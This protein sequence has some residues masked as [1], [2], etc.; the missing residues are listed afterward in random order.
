EPAA[1]P[2][3]GPHLRLR[4]GVIREIPHAARPVGPPGLFGP[5]TPAEAAGPL[6]GGLA[7]V[8]GPT[9]RAP[10]FS[11]A[12]ISHIHFD[13][14]NHLRFLDAAIPVHL[15]IGTK[16]ILDSWEITTRGMDLLAHD[17]RSEERRVGKEGRDA[18]AQCR[19]G[20]T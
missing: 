13:H 20:A 18:G 12:V 8:G 3:P 16:I 6:R 17:Y 10:R 7:P 5:G 11:A 1:V 2:E 15:G 9:A 14:T 4:P 19:R